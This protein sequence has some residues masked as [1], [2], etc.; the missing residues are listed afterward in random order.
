MFINL[1]NPQDIMASLAID[2]SHEQ[3]LA[4]LFISIGLI[5]TDLVNPEYPF[6]P[7]ESHVRCDLA[8]NN[9]SNYCYIKSYGLYA[10]AASAAS[11]NT[12]TLLPKPLLS[13]VV[14]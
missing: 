9:S 3:N 1:T 12:H 5:D 2:V 8:S 4:G 6:A 13:I 14:G 7:S 10:S 11:A